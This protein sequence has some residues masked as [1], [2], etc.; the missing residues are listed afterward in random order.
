[1]GHKTY[2][3][4]HFAMKNGRSN[5]AHLMAEL[6]IK[7]VQ[8]STISCNNNTTY[9]GPS[10]LV[11]VHVNFVIL[12][13]NVWQLFTLRSKLSSKSPF[14]T[15]FGFCQLSFRYRAGHISGMANQILVKTEDF[16]ILV[17]SELISNFE[18]NS[19]FI[20]LNLPD[21]L[22]KWLLTSRAVE[23]IQF[24]ILILKC[25]LESQCLNHIVKCNCCNL[26]TS[27]ISISIP[28]QTPSSF[29]PKL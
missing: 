26:I 13:T 18:K 5:M 24:Q 28:F 1:M 7:N 4:N 17:V 22:R 19:C 9:F 20:F 27:A 16:S 23:I 6:Y 29:P 12:L 25:T 11:Y 21:F 15:Y 3:D 14:F 8:R 2:L 10:I